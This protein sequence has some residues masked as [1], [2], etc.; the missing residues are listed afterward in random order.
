MSQK[1]PW[2]IKIAVYLI[3]GKIK[4]VTGLK[5]LPSGGAFI[6]VS[7]H[8]SFLDAIFMHAV[9]VSYTKRFIYSISKQE[10]KKTYG[11]FGHKYLGMLYIDKNNKKKIIN[12][13]IKCLRNNKILVIFPE[14][15]RNYNPNKLLKGK[16]GA[17]RLALKTKV[18]VIP[19]GLIMPKGK[20][21]FQLIKNFLFPGRKL[22]IHIGQAIYFSKYYDKKI[23]KNTLNNLTKKIMLAIGKLCRKS[24]PY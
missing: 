13:C 6:I 22:E 4:T 1:I 5:N 7:N 12:T 11:Q 18:P 17:V 2:F 21:V 3:K 14:A 9:I 8:Q 23:D 10:L 24:Y 16:T 15:K 20:K 19:I